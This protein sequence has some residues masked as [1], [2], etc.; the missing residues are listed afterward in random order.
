MS[1]ATTFSIVGEIVFTNIETDKQAKKQYVFP[2]GVGG[3]STCQTF[4]REEICRWEV[5][6]ILAVL[7]HFLV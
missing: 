4:P 5:K 7:K 1:C 6:R 2:E 3:N